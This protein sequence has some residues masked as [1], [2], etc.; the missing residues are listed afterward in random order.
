VS[1]LDKMVIG[2]PENNSLFCTGFEQRVPSRARER[3]AR[4]RRK[5]CA[6]RHRP[7]ARLAQT[8]RLCRTA[9]S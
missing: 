1:F 4:T 2:L 9:L 5:N 6:C 7:W 3:P 8:E